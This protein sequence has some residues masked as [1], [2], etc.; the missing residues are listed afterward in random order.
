M[1]ARTKRSIIFWVILSPLLITIL[2]PYAVMVTTAVKPREE[3]FA[4][5]VT[6]FGSEIRWENF[7]E[8]WVENNYGSAIYSSLYVSIGSTLLTLL[9]A[10][11]AS[12][13]LSRFQFRGKGVYRQFLLITQMISPIVLIVGLFR[14]L[15]ALNLVNNLNGLIIS[16]SAFSLAFAI[17][18]LQSYFSTIPIEV[19]EA[20][21]I[22][23]ATRFQS[24]KKIFL[25]LAVPSLVVTAVFTFI[26][27][28]NEF[29]LSM[30]LLVTESKYPLPLKISI[31][32]QGMYNL[33]WHHVMAA[34]FLA[35]IPVAIVFAW[36]QN[37]LVRGLSLGAVK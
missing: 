1:T 35:T 26:N 16:N 22:D 37:H 29:L 10:I 24:L 13:A 11:P 14:V 18:M 36:L 33:E 28:W 15:V 21:W 27:S 12:Y 20:S 5:D 4:A 6:W 9:I 3:I 19:E 2:L 17:W 23:G 34:T 32:A 7:V 8:M 31:M 30:T 25:P